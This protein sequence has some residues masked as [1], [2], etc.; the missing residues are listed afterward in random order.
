MFTHNYDKCPYCNA[1][2]CIETDPKEGQITCSACGVILEER[3]IDETNELRNFG[4]D[5]QGSG[6]KDLNR[7]G[8][9]TSEYNDSQK[10]LV[11]NIRGQKW[12]NRTIN[13]SGSNM[14][15]YY[16]LV[17]TLADQL[18]L[19]D[20]IRENTRELISGISSKKKFK[21]SSLEYTVA[22]VIFAACQINMIP[23][24]LAEL[25]SKLELDKKKLIKS[26]KI[27]K[28]SIMEISQYSINLKNN[29]INLVDKRCA[30]LSL[31]TV[32]SEKARKIVTI[33]S[34]KEILSGKQPNTISAASIYLACQITG[35]GKSKQEITEENKI[36]EST[37]NNSLN[38][39]KEYKDIIFEGEDKEKINKIIW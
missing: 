16:S 37:V 22:S 36:S 2:N 19:K 15:K 7:V 17:D 38:I 30:S 39:L 33:I 18:N 32:I 5:G 35:N 34:D 3:I 1:S 29:L 12:S 27:V 4:G 11:I 26:V 13:T 21:G 14:S 8:G 20:N 10:T 24:T 25:A 31:D 28:P 23:M 6:G 9:P